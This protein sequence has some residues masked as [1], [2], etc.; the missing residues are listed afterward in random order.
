[1]LYD[2]ELPRASLIIERAYSSSMI[3][4]FLRNMDASYVRRCGVSFIYW[5][6]DWHT[7]RTRQLAMPCFIRSSSNGIPHCTIASVRI[8]S[9]PVEARN[10]SRPSHK[11]P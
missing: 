3:A 7:Q 8:P 11:G 6:P 9:S 10:D 2:S 4:R 5:Q 1:M